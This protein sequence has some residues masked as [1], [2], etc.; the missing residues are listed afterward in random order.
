M[1]DAVASRK[2]APLLATQA[3]VIL[4][5]SP[6]LRK[7]FPLEAASRFALLRTCAGVTLCCTGARGSPRDQLI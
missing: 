3:G 6:V 1:F 2:L 7:S 5:L 4:L